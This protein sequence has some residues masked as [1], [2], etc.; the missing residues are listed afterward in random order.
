MAV[1][2]AIRKPQLTRVTNDSQL[3]GAVNALTESMQLFTGQNSDKLERAVTLKDLANSG[4][5]VNLGAGDGS[6]TVDVPPTNDEP[7][8]SVPPAMTGVTFS[9]T[10]NNILIFWNPAGYKNHAYVEVWIAAPTKTAGSTTTPTV[11]TDAN[12]H[13]ICT[14][15]AYYVSVLPGDSW[16]IWLRNVSKQ[17]VSGPWYSIDGNVVDVPADP[18]YII[19]KISG[20]IRESDLYADLGTKIDDTAKRSIEAAAELVVH[21]NQISTNAAE[22]VVHADQISTNAADLVVQA[23]NIAKH[24]T[25]I[26]QHTTSIAAANSAISSLQ[27]ISTGHGNEIASIESTISSHGSS[28]SSIQQVAATQAGQITTIQSNISTAQADITS[29]KQV[30]T[31]QDSTIATMQTTLDSHGSSITSIQQINATQSGQISSILTSISTAQSDITSIKQINSDQDKTL[32]T[33]SDTL[34]SHGSSIS[35][36]QAVNTTQAGQIS[37]IQTN[38]STAQADITAIKQVNTTQDSTLAT[39][40]STINSHGSSITSIQQVNTTQSGQISSILTSIDSINGSITNIQQV[41]SSQDSTIASQGSTISSHGSSIS[42]LNSITTTHTGQISTINSTLSSHGTSISNATSIATDANNLIRASYTVKIDAGGAVSGFGLSTDGTS[43]LFLIRADRFAIAEPGSAAITATEGRIP[44]IVSNGQVLIKNAAIDQ[45][46]IKTIVASQITADYINAL[47]LSAVR[48][49]GGTLNI[50][51][52]FV[53]DGTGNVTMNSATLVGVARSSNYTAGSAGWLLRQDGWA[54]LNN[55]VVRGTVYA[56]AGSFAGTVYAEKLVGGAYTRKVYASNTNA[57]VSS[58]S[59][60]TWYTAKRITVA[61]AMGVARAISISGG[62]AHVTLSITVQGGGS[63]ATDGSASCVLEA[64]IV[65]D[66]STVLASKQTST[67]IALIVGPSGGQ[68]TASKKVS[69]G[70]G[71]YG[72]VP[73]DGATHYFD[74]QYRFVSSASSAASVGVSIGSDSSDA[75]LVEMYIESGDLA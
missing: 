24:E 41:N 59:P 61:R 26:A 11:V 13:G 56:S 67:D 3:I 17:G 45:A 60:S 7:D 30:N 1:N 39:V 34:T 64:R 12:L 40:Q 19:D 28:I 23:A 10:F 16:R 51:N 2:K 8:M 6:V 22:L 15:T 44:F 27:T 4:F 29:I 74:L 14:T 63:N 54:E 46:F 66:G 65:R 47:T 49:T 9:A 75:A 31:T 53:V 38:I 43:S 20:E 33:I 32:A 42:N 55:V 57:D 69:V 71:L 70:A 73:G 68:S 36:I 50:G 48:I 21:A 18:A 62:F 58:P 37:T 35:S 52:N 72:S 5:S 25:V